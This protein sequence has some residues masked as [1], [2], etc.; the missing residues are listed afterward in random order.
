MNKTIIAVLIL[1]ILMLSAVMELNAKSNALEDALNRVSKKIAQST[2]IPLD[3]KFAFIDFRETTTN[4]R[5]SLS[6]AI[7][8]DLSIALIREMPGRL[9]IKNNSET[10]LSSIL[11][12]RD[13]VFDTLENINSFGK[14]SAANYIISGGYY[15][16]KN[17]AVITVNVINAESGIILFSE[18]IKL[19]REAI[20]KTLFPNN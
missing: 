4:K 1:P 13:N 8:D 7:E 19:S 3:A 2:E 9:V 18:R 11:L 20:S 16:N 17:N 6:Y 12:C 10:I 5:L 15:F 14:K